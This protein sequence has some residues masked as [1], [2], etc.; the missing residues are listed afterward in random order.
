MAAKNISKYISKG[1]K[2]FIWF[3]LITYIPLFIDPFYGILISFVADFFDSY[4][5][6]FFKVDEK[7]YHYID[8]KM[9]YIL[10]IALLVISF[11]TPIFLLIL[12]LFLFRSFGIYLFNKT[13]KR[14]FF[15]LTPN[16]IEFVYLIYLYDIKFGYSYLS[17][18]RT[19]FILVVFKLIQEILLHGVNIGQAYTGWRILK[20]PTIDTFKK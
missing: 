11:F 19:W 8:K 15:V 12:F 17:D 4:I 13:G 10:Y 7:K 16:L 3:R 5:L 2:A 9:D 14:I 20:L 18:Y 6:Y 1:E